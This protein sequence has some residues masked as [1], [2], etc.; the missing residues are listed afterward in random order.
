MECVPWPAEKKAIDIGSFYAD[1]SKLERAISGWTPTVTL[2]DGLRRVV[3]FYRENLSHYL[4]DS[5]YT[6][7]A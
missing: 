4:D 6:E 3:D 2:D 1:S 7:P 5:R